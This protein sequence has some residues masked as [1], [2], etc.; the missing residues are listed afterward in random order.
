VQNKIVKILAVILSLTFVLSLAACKKDPAEET[1]TQA[2]DDTTVSIDDTSANDE[3]TLPEETADGD[4]TTTEEGKT[5][6]TANEGTDPAPVDKKPETPEEIA[7]YYNAAANKVKKEKPAYT[8]TTTNHIGEITSTNNVI[9]KLIDRVVPMFADD[10]KP[11]TV[12]Y[13]KGDPAGRIP[14]SGQSYGGK[15]QA[16]SLSGAS[17]ADKGSY[18]ELT[19]KFK[20]EKLSA[21]PTN[22]EVSKVRHG[23]A[24]NLLTKEIVDKEVKAIPAFIVTLGTFAPE[25]KGCHVI[26]RVDKATG[27][28]TYAELKCINVSQVEAEAFKSISLNASV[29]FGNTEVYKYKY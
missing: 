14:V 28:L 16:S 2:P 1:T 18:Y 26:A 6:S 5:D 15:I 24:F 10:T 8:I 19:M 7:A 25:Y 21:L 27:R 29:E 23:Q 12:E 3:T 11:A 22:A 20:P 9:N 4:E 13:G 17:C